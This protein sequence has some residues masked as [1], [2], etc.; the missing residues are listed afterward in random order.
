MPPITDSELG[1]TE[2]FDYRIAVMFEVSRLI[3]N[4]SKD[5]ERGIII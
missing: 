1:T 4:Y 5:M 3:Y 2:V